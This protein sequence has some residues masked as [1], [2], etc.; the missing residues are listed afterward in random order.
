MGTYV[1]MITYVQYIVD[2][3]H[4]TYTRKEPVGVVGQMG[5]AYTV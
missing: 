5:S 2:G 3:D 4:M 1:N